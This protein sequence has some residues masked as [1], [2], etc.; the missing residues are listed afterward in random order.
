MTMAD[1]REV[2]NLKSWVWR[3][4]T[5][6]ETHAKCI[7]CLQVSVSELRCCLHATMLNSTK[8]GILYHRGL[9]TLHFAFEILKSMRNTSTLAAHLRERHGITEESPANTPSQ[10]NR[11]PSA[12][13]FQVEE[14][15]PPEVI[16]PS[17][18]RSMAKKRKQAQ[19]DPFLVTKHCLKNDMIRL[20]CESNLS[21]NGIATSQTVR[22]VLTRA[23]PGDPTPPRSAATL[24]KV[25]SEEAQKVRDKL[26]SKLELIREEGTGTT[27]KYVCCMVLDYAWS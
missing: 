8:I 12:P 21:L 3:W 6:N 19:I 4:F 9:E 7:K 1:F 16:E 13:S 27:S 2:R 23:Y 26:R 20:V 15:E 25:L 10:N 18:E 5:K 11:V 14:E 24:R 22:R 17:L